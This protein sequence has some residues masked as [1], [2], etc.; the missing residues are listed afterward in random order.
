MERPL[1]VGAAVPDMTLST[2]D[3]TRFDPLAEAAKQ[4]LVMVFYRG[5]WCPY[6]T[7]HLAELGQIGIIGGSGLDK[8]EFLEDRQEV[9]IDTPY[10]WR[11]NE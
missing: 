10:E 6:C 9:P 11:L 3:G 7:R 8:P 2:P 1:T 4:P 5:G